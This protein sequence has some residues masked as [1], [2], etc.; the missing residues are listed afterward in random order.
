MLRGDKIHA[1]GRLYTVDSIQFT[2]RR[3]RPTGG[4][5]SSGLVA[6]DARAQRL[7][8]RADRRRPQRPRDR[9]DQ[10]RHD[11]DTLMSS[12]GVSSK[13]R[14]T[15]YAAAAAAKQRRQKIIAGVLG[16]VLIAVLA[17]EVPQLLKLVRGNE[18]ARAAGRRS[19]AAG[20][21]ARRAARI[22]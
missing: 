12:V 22:C 4:Q 15:A 6:G 20:R 10:Y 14:G 2:G 8:L 9:H 11:D 5:R 17:Y 19:A 13:K 7:R 21:A 18:H 3:R 1:N 16:V